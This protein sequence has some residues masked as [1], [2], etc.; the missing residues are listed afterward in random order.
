VTQD[1][2]TNW[3]EI[4]G[5]LPYNKHV[6][7]IVASKY[8]EATVYLTL[9]GRRDD[10]FNDYI[11]KSEDYGETW[12]DISGNIPGGPVNVIREDP[13]KKNILYV[14]ND[15]GVYVSVDE[16]GQWHSLSHGLPNCFVWDLKIH[17]RDHVLVIATNG[18]GMYAMDDISKIHETN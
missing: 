2:G 11:Y 6:S 5:D 18:R 8:D 15:L 12:T 3:E 10:D 13:E 14:G 16:G 7:R 1:Q 9:N 4:T 17:P